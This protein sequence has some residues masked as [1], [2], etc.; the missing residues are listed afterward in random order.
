LK[1]IRNKE[2]LVI[3]GGKETYNLNL[4]NIESSIH[5]L[6]EQIKEINQNLI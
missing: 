6:L 2:E 1:K 4:E 5:L 3:L